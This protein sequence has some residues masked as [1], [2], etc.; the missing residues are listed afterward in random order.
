MLDQPSGEM[1][2]LERVLRAFGD[3]DEKESKKADARR[4]NKARFAK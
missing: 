3:Y 4:K 2:R 1:M